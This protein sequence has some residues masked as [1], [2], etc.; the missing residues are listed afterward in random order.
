MSK[1][2]ILVLVKFLK[3]QKADVEAKVEAI[4]SFMGFN[5]VLDAFEFNINENIDDTS[6]KKIAQAILT[7]LLA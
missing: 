1:S 7:G 6:R 3:T 4:I 5:A 2:E